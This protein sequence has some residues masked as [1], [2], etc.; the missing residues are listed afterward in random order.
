MRLLAKVDPNHP[1]L[2]GAAQW[3]MLQRNGGV[4]WDSTEQTAMVLFGLVDYL[5]ASHELEADF[6]ADIL[7]NG[8]S[9]GQRHFTSADALNGASFAIDIDAAHLQPGANT[10]QVVRRSRSE[11][12]TSELQSLRHLVC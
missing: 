7:V 1:L 3:L 12:H 4:W 2:S 5:A 8:H 10:V 11:E 6:T 9:V